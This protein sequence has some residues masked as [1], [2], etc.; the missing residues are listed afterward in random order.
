MLV[1]ERGEKGEKEQE[2]TFTYIDYLGQMK[3]PL[4]GNN[5]LLN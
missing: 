3:T 4:Q 5:F 2:Y 1:K